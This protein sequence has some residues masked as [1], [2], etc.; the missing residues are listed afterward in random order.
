MLILY[1]FKRVI[2]IGLVI[3]FLFEGLK[4]VSDA[5]R[6]HLPDE[7]TVETIKQLHHSYPQNPTISDVLFKTTSWRTGSVA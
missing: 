3:L 1:K 4:Q 5:V 6:G 7:L 2:S